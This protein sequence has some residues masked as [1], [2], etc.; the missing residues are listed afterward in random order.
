MKG[1]TIS[2]DRTEELVPGIEAPGEVPAGGEEEIAIEGGEEATGGETT[3]DTSVFQE[4]SEFNADVKSMIPL[5]ENIA[6]WETEWKDIKV[7]VT[8]VEPK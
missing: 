7:K 1:Q 6:K 8:P 5:T 4:R 2:P 3:Q